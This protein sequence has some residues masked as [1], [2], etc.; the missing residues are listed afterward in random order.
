MPR[1]TVLHTNDYHNYLLPQ[2]AEKLKALRAEL[3]S[4]GLLLDAG[5]AI[6]SGNVTFKPGGEPIL[7]TMSDIGYDTM[8]VGNREFHFSSIGFRAKVS[9]AKFPVLCANV[10]AKG[11]DPLPVVPS[12]NFEVHGVKITVFG[13]TVPMITER[14]LSRHASA[15]VFD[16][17][18]KVA[19]T[20]VPQLRSGCN[21]LVCL[22][23][24][25]LAKDHQL[26]HAVPGIDLLV[27]GHTHVV[28]PTGETVENTL[29][30]QGGSHGRFLG[31]VQVEGHPGDWKLSAE[32]LDFRFEDE[33][34]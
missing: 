18:I 34:V 16:D 27:G 29:I 32:L 19:Q 14:M 30:V 22:S 28:L 6:S 33:N 7:D 26:V 4:D 15:W 23:H 2:A 11:T 31:R 3:G 12:A 20:L 17:P 1:F 25:G 10:R 8:T 9:R 24:I 21:F 13:I 5:D